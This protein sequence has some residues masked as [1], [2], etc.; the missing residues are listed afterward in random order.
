[1]IEEKFQQIY[2]RRPNNPKLWYDALDYF[3]AG[4]G[5][6][7]TGVKD[8]LA[9][10]KRKLALYHSDVLAMCID[11]LEKLIENI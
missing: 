11:D 1:M 7:E 4:W 6:K 2:G 8:L 9:E 3:V 5:A 10:W